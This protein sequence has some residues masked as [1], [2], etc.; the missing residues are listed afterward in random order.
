MIESFR[1]FS[2][3]IDKYQ[4]VSVAYKSLFKKLKTQNNGVVLHKYKGRIWNSKTYCI[5]RYIGPHELT[6]VRCI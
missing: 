1:E 6:T 2:T 3:A 4:Y 5:I